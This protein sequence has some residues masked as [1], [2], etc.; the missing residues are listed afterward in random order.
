MKDKIVLFLFLFTPSIAFSEAK[1]GVNYM[2]YNDGN[3]IKEKSH[4]LWISINEPF[5]VNE[6]FGLGINYEYENLYDTINIG[7][8]IKPYV[9]LIKN[10]LK[11]NLI[12]SKLGKKEKKSQEYKKFTRMGISLEYKIWE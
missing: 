6:R 12:V 1:I 4:K 10:S 2:G 8:E 3:I 5:M 11:M 7:S 9:D